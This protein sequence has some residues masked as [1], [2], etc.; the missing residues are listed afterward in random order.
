[1]TQPM[2]TGPREGGLETVR[3]ARAP[4]RLAWA[5]RTRYMGGGGG[6]KI[7]TW[8]DALER[9]SGGRCNVVSIRGRK[10]AVETEVLAFDIGLN[11]FRE[12]S[13]TM[14]FSEKRLAATVLGGE[15]VGTGAMIRAGVG[16]AERAPGK[17]G[18][19]FRGRPRITCRGR[20]GLMET[21]RRTGRRW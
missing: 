10:K 9:L 16:W 2:M 12:G 8:F 6:Q 11:L 7:Q 18:R 14:A 13:A 4:S 17:I 5:R 20:T 21:W 15:L 3:W 1:M 19:S